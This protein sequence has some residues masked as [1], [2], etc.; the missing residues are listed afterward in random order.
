MPSTISKLV[1]FTSLER[2]VFLL[3]SI[4]L[5]LFGVGASGLEVN[6]S[7]I[8]C[9]LSAIFIAFLAIYNIFVAN[10]YLSK[11]NNTYLIKKLD[12][13]TKV[14]TFLLILLCCVFS[15][16]IMINNILKIKHN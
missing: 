7:K 4:S 13:S 10:N 2:N 16:N 9:K 1:L 12:F 3:S 5:A 14:Y 15:Y 8:L 11:K 6:E